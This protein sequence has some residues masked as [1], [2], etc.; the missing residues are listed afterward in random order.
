ML[1]ALGTDDVLVVG[2][3]SATHQAG[4][5][6]GAEEAIVVPVAV[7][8]GDEFGTS[9]T[10]DGLVTGRATLG[11]QFPET[12]GTEGLLVAAGEALTC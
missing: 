5:T 8:E 9:D 6:G 7:L 3:E 2:D 10:G 4:L 12:F 1:G 11:E